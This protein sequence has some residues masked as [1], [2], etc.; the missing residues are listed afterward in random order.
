VIVLDTHVLAWADNDERKLGRKAR[1]LI[2]RLWDS[3][4]V[5]V[6]AISFWELAL[7]QSKQRFKLPAGVDEWRGQLLIAG[8]IE[9]PVDGAI[10]IRAVALNGLPDDP[11]D[12]LIVA[13]ALHHGAALLTADEKL[14]AWT[15]PLVRYDACA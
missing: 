15:H 14:L 5:A 10:G 6:C 3:G 13:T 12:R 2:E 4:Q 8:L 7:L 1:A 11:A 9:L